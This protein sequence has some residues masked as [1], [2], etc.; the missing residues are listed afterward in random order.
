MCPSRECRIL[1]R[2]QFRIKSKKSHKIKDYPVEE[3]MLGVSNFSG[4]KTLL[5]MVANVPP[6][7]LFA[8]LPGMYP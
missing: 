4:E 6:N 1:F 7:S 3:N 5:E 2:Y 8:T